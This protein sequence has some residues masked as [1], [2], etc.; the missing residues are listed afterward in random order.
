M[1]RKRAALGGKN[2]IKTPTNLNV[3]KGMKKGK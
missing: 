2:L 3:K 1:A